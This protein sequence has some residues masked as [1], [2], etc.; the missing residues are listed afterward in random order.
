[1]KLHVICL[2]LALNVSCKNSFNAAGGGDGIATTTTTTN[3]TFEN[4][5]PIPEQTAVSNAP[6]G[7]LADQSV[8]P[9]YQACA[10]L[11]GAGKVRYPAKC[12]PNEVMAVIN[13]GK[14]QE[15][16]CCPLQ[17]TNILSSNPAEQY[18]TRIGRCLADE[19][20][21]GMVN[22]RDSQIY[23]TKINTQYLKLGP[24]QP[25]IYAS[26]SGNNNPAL[27]AIAQVY[28]VGDCCVCPEK[29]VLVG[30]HV[31]N[32]NVCQDQCVAI[33]SK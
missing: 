10:A 21:V 13:D 33:I 20:G 12:N 27:Q 23:C 14:T 30:G 19:V 4:R 3:V 2:S 1:M 9:N 7:V 15:M 8:T 11:P 26:R 16:T 31:T 24:P 32:D 17:G 6:T 25:A 29:T 18:Q 28:N 22:A 5:E